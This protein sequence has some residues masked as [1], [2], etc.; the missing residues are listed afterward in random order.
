[1]LFTFLAVR[2]SQ[3]LKELIARGSLDYNSWKSLI[4][5]VENTCQVSLDCFLPSQL[6]ISCRNGR[7]HNIILG[8][9]K[10]LQEILAMET[11][12]LGR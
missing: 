2:L 11:C 8:A 1:M 10:P 6:F 9:I 3:K 5:E 4:V 7:D 12:Y